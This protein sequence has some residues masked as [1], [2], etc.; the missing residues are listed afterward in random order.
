MDDLAIELFS[1]QINSYRA[2]KI[3]GKSAEVTYAQAVRVWK[4]VFLAAGSILAAIA[5]IQTKW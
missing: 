2:A 4:K 3:R 1:A 5:Q